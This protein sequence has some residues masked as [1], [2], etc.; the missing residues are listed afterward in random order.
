MRVKIYLKGTKI[1]LAKYALAKTVATES[2][3]AFFPDGSKNWEILRGKNREKEA[4][5]IYHFNKRIGGIIISV[6]SGYCRLRVAKRCACLNFFEG[7]GSLC[8]N[9][10]L[11]RYGLRLKRKSFGEH[12]LAPDGY[13]EE[14]VIKALRLAS[15]GK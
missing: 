12:D 4:T 1:A 6:C 15:G 14:D 11:L 5:H 2:S 7:K 9:C 13:L 3:K 10:L 8:D